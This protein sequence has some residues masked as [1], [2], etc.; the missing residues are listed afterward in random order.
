MSKVVV[1]GGCGGIGRVAVRGVLASEA[2]DE[3][4]IADLRGEDTARFAAELGGAAR[5]A[6]VDVTSA[7]SLRNVLD[8]ARVVLNCVGPFYRFGPPTLAA[9]IDAGID[10]VDVCDDL[11]PTREMLAMSGR[12]KERGVSALVGMGNSPGLANLFVRLC[13]DA[14]LD[15]VESVDIHHVHG[16]EPIEGP[17]VVKHRIFAMTNDVPLFLDGAFVNVRQLEASGL[18]HVREVEFRGVGKL[19]VYPYPHPETITLPEHIP[20]L[21]RATNMGVIFPLRYFELTQTMV[22]TGACSE[23]AVRVGVEGQ[24]V[25]PLEFSVAHILSQRGKIL[26]EEGVKGPSGC[27]QVVVGGMKDGAA[28]TFIFSLSSTTAGAGEGTGIPAAAGA[29]LMG[30]GKITE[31]GVFPPEAGVKPFDA[32]QLALAL[33]KKLGMGGSESVH[34]EQV[35]AHGNRSTLPIPL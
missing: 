19:P 27:L 28:R 34:I 9:A 33:G 15:R 30:Q 2:F 32:L 11:A 12:A 4:V 24:P 31:K 14:L 8:G 17:A 26:A 18:A 35:D 22:R 1:L 3:V 20:G 25:I 29:V 21:K 13:A 16:G 23:E 6:S 7:K 10:Y 5:S